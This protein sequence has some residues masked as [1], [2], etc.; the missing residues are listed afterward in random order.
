LE[1]EPLRFM[2]DLIPSFDFQR[3]FVDPWTSGLDSYG[4]MVLMAFLVTA[5]CGLIGNYLILR[6]MALVGDAI[7]HSV[8]PGLA[9]AYLITDELS[10]PVMLLGALG[11]GLLTTVMI[12]FIHTRSRIKSDAA[13]GI[14]FCTLFAIG[15]VLINVFASRVHLDAEC[16]LYGELSFLQRGVN[17]FAPRAVLIMG[18]V[19]IV[20]AALIVL[21][22]KELLVSSFDAMLAASLGFA[23]KLIHLALMAVLS[24]VIVSAFE[25]VGAILVIAM[26]ILPGATAQL[27]STR[28][29]VCLWLSVAHAAMSAVL[30]LHMGIWLNCSI[31]AA[32]VVAGTGLFAVAWVFGPQ[33]ALV[34]W[35]RLRPARSADRLKA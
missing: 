27:I 16:V 19:G 2:R 10:L 21:F 3:V 15:V 6:R 22:Y 29:S 35:K 4:W 12:E 32:V 8:L 7:S 30:G 33:S 13:I 34:K 1:L 9:V 5:T 23:P 11:A 18:G 17:E 24:I 28:L 14:T 20:V 31:A 25:S 26:L